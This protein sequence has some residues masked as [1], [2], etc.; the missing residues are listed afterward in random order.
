MTGT[1]EKWPM[2]KET[3]PVQRVSGRCGGPGVSAVAGNVAWGRRA[4]GAWR[5]PLAGGGRGGLPVIDAGLLARDAG[6]GRWST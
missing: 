2:I 6:R 5:E 4:A 3:G 1:H